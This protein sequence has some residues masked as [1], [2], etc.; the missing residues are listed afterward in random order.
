MT[1]FA[2]L[3]GFTRYPE[4]EN[5]EYT[6]EEDQTEDTLTAKTGKGQPENP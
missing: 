1:V 3:L 4:H 2:L 6:T 5:T